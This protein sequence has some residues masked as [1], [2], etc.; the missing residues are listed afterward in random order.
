MKRLILDKLK[1]WKNSPNRKPLIVYGARQI[2]KKH[3]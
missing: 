1:E 2:G 3:S